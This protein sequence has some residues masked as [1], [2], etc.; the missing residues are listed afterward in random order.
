MN[1]TTASDLC[2]LQ[3][4]A[5]NRSFE[6]AAP[7]AVPVAELLPTLVLYA[8]GDE[9]ED[10]DESGLEHDGWVLQQLGDDPLDEDETLDSLGLCHGETLYLRPRRDQL[11]PIHFDDLIDG[12]ATGMAERPDKWR[13]AFTRV[14]L[15]SLALTGLLLGLAVPAVAGLTLLTAVTCAASAVVMLISAWAASRAMGDLPAASG[16]AATAALYM[17]TAGAAMPTGDPGTALLG[18][19]LVTGAMTAAGATVLGVAAVAGAVPFFSGLITAE[20]LIVLGALGLMLL[21]NGTPPA[22]AAALGLLTLLVG[23]YSPQLAFRL[24][25]LRLPPLP[26]N[27]QQLQQGID[28]FPARGVLDRSALADRFQSALLAAT[29]AVLTACLIVLALAEGWVATTLCILVS[30]VMLLQTRGLAGAW[31]RAFMTAPPCL[32]LATLVVSFAASTGAVGRSLTLLGV[33]AVVT[34]LGVL[35]WSLPGTR[36]LPHW[37]RAAEIIQ[38]LITIAVFP[39]VLASFGVFSVIRAIGG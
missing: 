10:L 13:P 39:L 38:S 17:G 34:V 19:Q 20:A 33:F 15:Q 7:T 21:P 5:P 37:G 31:Q 8:E 9:G 1:D 6:I 29:G 26:S 36:P 4:R 12:I 18:A 30:L 35:S 22:V 11:P 24:S 23:T 27:P 3:I 28:P 14:L 16:L 25:G 2:R 32:G